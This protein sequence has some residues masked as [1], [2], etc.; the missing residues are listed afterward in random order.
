MLKR[1]QIGYMMQSSQL[2][3]K[4]EEQALL[5]LMEI[6]GF[7][8]KIEHGLFFIRGDV[9]ED[10]MEVVTNHEAYQRWKATSLIERVQNCYEEW[11]ERGKP[12]R[13]PKEWQ[14]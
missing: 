13:T 4:S 8:I 9:W 3:L 14:E 7:P 10:T 1:L 2:N 12:E 6:N 5:S 11:I